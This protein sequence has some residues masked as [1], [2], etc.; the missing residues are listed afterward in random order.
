VLVV[1]LLLVVVWSAQQ[2]LQ[3]VTVQRLAAAW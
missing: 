3:T 2:L 1:L